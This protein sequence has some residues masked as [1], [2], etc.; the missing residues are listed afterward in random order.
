MRLTLFLALILLSAC[1]PPQKKL[2]PQLVDNTF[3]KHTLRWGGTFRG[4]ATEYHTK[5][6]D[7]GGMLAICAVRDEDTGIAE[8]LS[9]T[10]FSR[11]FV[12]VGGQRVA[13]AKFIS[14]A[15]DNARERWAHCIE[16]K[17]RSEGKLYLPVRIRGDAIT[18][19][20]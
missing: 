17:T 2:P 9:D 8:E 20:N 13:P 12:H 18:V 10:W 14:A 3:N 16:T 11:A 4:A 5:L 1:V 7:S 6:F 15:P 19:W